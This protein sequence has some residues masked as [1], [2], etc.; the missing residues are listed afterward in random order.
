MTPTVQR[1]R[2]RLLALT[3]LAVVL[4]A[5]GYL[6]YGGIGENLV[7]FLSPKELLAKGTAAYDVPVRLGGQVVPGSVQWNP[8]R[9]ELRFRVTDGSEQVNVRSTDGGRG[10][11]TVPPGRRIRVP[12]PHG[13]AFER[14]PGAETG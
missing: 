9:L 10:R 3:A 11:R 7:Y 4:G 2:R 5:F 1:G 13:E 14:I 12:Q 6:L 8:E